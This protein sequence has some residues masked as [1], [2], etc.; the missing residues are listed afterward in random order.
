[1]LPL[2][3]RVMLLLLL[4]LLLSSPSSLAGPNVKAVADVVLSSNDNDGVAEA[5]SKF[6]L[7]PRGLEMMNYVG[8]SSPAASAAEVSAD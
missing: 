6:V 7:Q 1:M 8:A 3:V 4:L 2:M 5:I